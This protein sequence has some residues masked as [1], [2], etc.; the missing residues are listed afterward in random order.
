[1]TPAAGFKNITVK[2]ETVSRVDG[3]RRKLP[4]IPS[5]PEIFQW[6]LEYSLSREKDFLKFAEKR[7]G[8]ER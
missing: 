4:E 2:D 8:E 1:M 3:L 5:R 6:L 7:Q